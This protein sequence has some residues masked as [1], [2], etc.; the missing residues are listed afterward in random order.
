MAELA[1]ARDSKSR[2]LH[3]ECGFD[4]HFRHHL[5]NRFM[6]T[7]K[8]GLL[9]VSVLFFTSCAPVEKD[10]GSVGSSGL[11]QIKEISEDYITVD[12]VEISGSEVINAAQDD[13]ETYEITPEM[14]ISITIGKSEEGKFV[15]KNVTW[16]E[17]YNL[18]TQTDAFPA[19]TV[20]DFSHTE[21]IERNSQ[22]GEELSYEVIMTLSEHS[23]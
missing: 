6:K 15:A 5:T 3:R 10:S 16:E 22:T 18:K 13:V 12:Y 14:K 2:S 8:T 1:D 17:F 20:F 9:I 23:L 7:F 21:T 4:P 19:E 11:V